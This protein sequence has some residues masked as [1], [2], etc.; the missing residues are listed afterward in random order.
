MV[1][2]INTVI[3]G[4]AALC[5]S[6]L[7]Q[8]A[9][10]SHATSLRN[11]MLPRS[12][13]ALTMVAANKARR[14]ENVEGNLFVDESCIDCD[15]CRWMAPGIYGR[16]NSQSNVIKQPEGEQERREAYRAMVSCPTGSIRLEQPDALVKDARN[17]FPFPVEGLP[18]VYH[19]GFHSKDSYGGTAWLLAREGGAVIVD[20]PRYSK[21]LAQAIVATLGGEQPKYMFLTH[22]D[23]VADH[24][25]W[26]QAFPDMQRIMHAADT[27]GRSS[28][29]AG[30]IEMELS[31]ATATRRMPPASSHIDTPPPCPLHPG[32]HLAFSAW[33]NRLDG[34]AR[35]NRNGVDRQ[36]RTIAALGS[37]AAPPFTA[38][39]PG[40]ARVARFADGPA[41]ARAEVSAAAAAFAADARAEGMWR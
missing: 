1:K 27:G 15:T 33:R 24:A 17:D 2:P 10:W 4:C 18:G 7:R 35:V 23:D 32:D 22:K 37:D 34:F 19:L 38:I 28:V 41:Q 6:H 21:S 26:A 30:V 25:K 5:A 36:A 14:K 13:T 9:A 20:S 31:D 8:A 39:L 3:L 16:E 29:G 40:H 12:R 11:S